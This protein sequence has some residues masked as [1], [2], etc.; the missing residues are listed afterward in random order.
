L[1]ENLT[2]VPC[3]PLPIPA[4]LNKGVKNLFLQGY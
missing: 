1:A 3:E 4:Q 2:H